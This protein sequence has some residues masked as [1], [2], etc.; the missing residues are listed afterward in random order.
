MLLSVFF[1]FASSVLRFPHRRRMLRTKRHLYWHFDTLKG[2]FLYSN[3]FLVI[4][5]RT[6]AFRP[7]C[8]SSRLM[9]SE[10]ESRCSLRFSRSTELPEKY[11]HAHFVILSSISDSNKNDGHNLTSSGL[12]LVYNIRQINDPT[13]RGISCWS[14]WKLHK[15]QMHRSNGIECNRKEKKY[16]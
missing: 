7:C 15:T 3:L 6:V 12:M 16:I 1:S 14:N 5:I 4:E 9:R 13:E 2:R 8:D 11:G 10:F